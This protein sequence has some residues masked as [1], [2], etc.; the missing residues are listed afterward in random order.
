MK[1]LYLDEDDILRTAVHGRQKPI[2]QS[3]SE[4]TYGLRQRARNGS[5]YV[6]DEH[7][8]QVLIEL[9]VR[10]FDENQN[11]FATR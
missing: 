9:V 1:K 8:D 5:Q 7:F 2:F 4:I 3:F 11:R 6:G 10:L